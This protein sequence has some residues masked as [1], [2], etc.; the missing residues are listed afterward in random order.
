MTNRLILLLIGSWLLA[1]T[2]ARAISPGTTGYN[3]KDY[4]AKGDGIALD[5]KAINNTIDAAAKAGGG[6]VFLP[7]GNYLSGSIRLKSNISLYLDQGAVIIATKSEANGEYDPEEATVNTTYQDYGHSHFHNSLI[8]GED[9]HDISILGPGMIWGKGLLRDSKNDSKLGNKA[10]AL[11]RCRN[12]IIRDISILTGGWFGILATGTDNLTISNIK[13]DTNRDGMDIDCCKNVRV[14]DCFVNSPYDDGICLKS[15]YALGYARNTENVTITNCQVSGYDVGTLLD[16]TFKRS[17]SHPTGRIKLGTESN[18]GFKN[19]TISNCVFDYCRGLALE[20]VDGAELEDVA[21]T[22]ITMRDVVSDPIFLRLGSR[23]RGPAGTPVGQL[24]RILI[25]N[26]VIYNAD[27][28]YVCTISGIPGHDIEDVTLSNIKLY[29]KGGL[30][31][32]GTQANPPEN[33]EMYPEPGMFGQAPAYGFFIRHAKNIK[34]TAVEINTIKSDTRPL[35]IAN[36]V[37]GLCL[38]ELNAPRMT[39]DNKPVFNQ[40]SDLQLTDSPII[41]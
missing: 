23:M 4:G 14:S 8:W 9:L 38:R 7:A 40:V 31:P 30:T 28:H 41:K 11:L 22:N 3:V 36:D 12:V 33:E 26:V 6:T 13:E 37:K 34:I 29:V 24:R 32:N 1:T 10:I 21:V 27:P 19:I 2:T 18:G 5:S 35:L 39:L 25:S 17:V 15:T 20:T 16:G